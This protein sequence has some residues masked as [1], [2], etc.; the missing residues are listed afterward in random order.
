[1]STIKD[2]YT[3][4]ELAQILGVVRMTVEKRAKRGRWE[5]RSRAGK[6]G[7]NEWL[8]SSMPKATRERVVAALLAQQEPDLPAVLE[9]AEILPVPTRTGLP[10]TQITERQRRTME[11]R[12]VFVREVEKLAAIAGKEAAV[13]NL[14]DAARENRLAGHLQ[15]LVREANDRPGERV[16]RGL[17][18]RNL[19]LWC[20]LFANG[21]QAALVPGHRQRDM[22]IPAWADAF[23]A[24]YKTPQHPSV[25]DCLR[26]MP[27]PGEPPAAHLVYRFLQKIGLPS[28]MSGRATGNA[29][30]KLRPHKIRTT[31]HLLP[32]DVYT[33]D[34]TTF[35][36]EIQN[37]Q[38]GQPFKPEI[39][40]VL[41]VATRRCVGVS[42][43]LSESAFTILD[44]LRL[45][46]L[47]GGV[48][49][50]F[51]C[52]NGSGYKNKL[53]LEPAQG[54]MA[55]LG[56]EMTN[57]IPN[58]PRG[59]GLME[60]AV[61]TLCTPLAKRLPSCTHKDMDRD[62][63]HKV[64]KLTRKDLK[65]K[66]RSD[67]LPTWPEFIKKLGGRIDEYNATPHSALGLIETGEGKRRHMSP[68]E[69]WKDFELRGWKPVRV[70]D[71]VRD[72]LFMPGTRRTVRNGMV[73]LFKQS[74]FASDLE[75]FHLDI[76]EVRYDIWDASRVHIWTRQGEKVCTAELDG[77]AIPYFPESRIEAAR[78][79]RK[80]G[81]VLRLASKLEQVAPGAK[82][83]LPPAETFE[84]LTVA[85]SVQPQAVAEAAEAM[86]RVRA[87][88][89]IPQEEPRPI[90]QYPF[91]K[92]EW[93]MRH[94]AKQNIKDVE[95]LQG[96]VQ[97]ED[98][99]DLH[100][101][102]KSLGIAWTGAAQAGTGDN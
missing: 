27:G 60:R 10:L 14:V 40:L 75:E 78:E 59:K 73:T 80:R 33:A 4:N 52:D 31:G 41:D 48:P 82:V 100:D 58:R 98:Y 26:R 38:N 97:E 81:Q 32:G 64:Y 53:M 90:F 21:G 88:R 18:R 72:D 25:A 2:A 65:E 70:P 74:Y 84:T 94:P 12:L 9:P 45:A 42:V 8:L 6:G 51:Y 63:A 24:L 23:L 95:W 66:G 85:D 28:R 46:C 29:L 39:T 54:M 19:Y 93:L 22:S 16:D 76:V 77:N 49:A 30:L 13:R 20:S 79:H 89:Q 62:A 55:R 43:G 91:E 99:A 102:Y 35:D 56:I 68:N 96:Y 5:S 71:E 15:A 92:Y 50:M 67:L 34:G 3:S 86:E 57:S 11:A 61:Q 36:A 1:M 44:A 47:F 83:E 101:H 87:E 69:C 37:P 7:G 17:S